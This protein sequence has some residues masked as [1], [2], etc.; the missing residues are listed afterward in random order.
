MITE[1]VDAMW[2]C[3]QIFSCETRN[4]GYE[5]VTLGASIKAN[6]NGRQTCSFKVERNDMDLICI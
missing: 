2:I 5:T 1:N 6:R 3:P 4:L